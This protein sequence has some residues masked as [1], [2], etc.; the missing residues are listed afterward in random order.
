MP[1]TLIGVVG[2]TPPEEALSLPDGAVLRRA[3]QQ[4][5]AH[6]HG[7]DGPNPIPY[8]ASFENALIE[9][10]PTPKPLS[11]VMHKLEIVVQLCV[12]AAVGIGPARCG[13]VVLQIGR[14][15]AVG[16]YH[17]DDFY[18]GF[19]PPKQTQMDR[20]VILWE[21]LTER[22]D[23]LTASRIHRGLRRYQR[24]LEEFDDEAVFHLVAANEALVAPEH[25]DTKRRKRFISRVSGIVA[26][27]PNQRQKIKNNLEKYWDCRSGFAH[28][29]HIESD[30]G[31]NLLRSY[32]HKVLQEAITRPERF[33]ASK[34]SNL[35]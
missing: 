13:D 28:G 31:L 6:Y 25:G 34:V 35:A 22:T 4:E 8:I 11:E 19:V 2:L 16:S 21:T 3:E 18:R 9:V 23:P 27:R 29:D 12:D 5:L 20:V 30:K 15:I 10:P 1:S 24:A 17:R 14:C 32:T 7:S 26:D 33:T